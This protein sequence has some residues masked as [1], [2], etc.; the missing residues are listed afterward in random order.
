MVFLLW[1]FRYGEGIVQ[2]TNRK[3]GENHS[4]KKIL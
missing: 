4:S 1:D 2:T 3:G